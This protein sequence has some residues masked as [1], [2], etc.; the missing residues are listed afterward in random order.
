MS[1]IFNRRLENLELQMQRLEKQLNEMQKIVLGSPAVTESAVPPQ[2]DTEPRLESHTYDRSGLTT[3][4]RSINGGT[5]SDLMCSATDRD[6]CRNCQESPLASTQGDI[7]S[8]QSPLPG[9]PV[10]SPLPK[11]KRCGFEIQD[12]PIPDFISIGLITIDQ[13]VSF[14]QA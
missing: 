1:D 2:P 12:E 7:P 8:I 11:R 6:R 5:Q 3:I 13:A 4:P 10:H 9:E 14:F